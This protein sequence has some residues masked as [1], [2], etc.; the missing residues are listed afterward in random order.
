MFRN[1]IFLASIISIGL[2]VVYS[3]FLISNEKAEARYNF[4]LEDEGLP[5]YWNCTKTLLPN[6]NTSLICQSSPFAIT[7]SDNPLLLNGDS[8]GNHLGEM[9]IFGSITWI[10]VPE[11][12]TLSIF[13]GHL[14]PEI[15]PAM[16]P[17]EQT[18]AN[19]AVSHP[20]VN[21]V[22][23]DQYVMRKLDNGQIIAAPLSSAGKQKY[24]YY[25][26]PEPGCESSI[27]NPYIIEYRA[28]ICGD[29]SGLIIT[30]SVIHFV[31]RVPI[32]N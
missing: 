13:P 29:T 28:I 27:Q 10:R 25:P 21:I 30:D 8:F 14:P 23:Q 31:Y 26:E 2:I 6:N 12:Y 3:V 7:D 19:Y 32:A 17:W 24:Q 5:L 22:T 9:G 20:D 4:S 16:P 11:G 18:I 1:C 15:I